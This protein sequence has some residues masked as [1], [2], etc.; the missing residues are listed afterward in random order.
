MSETSRAIGLKEL[1]RVL[2]LSVPTVS[3]ALGGYSDVSEKTRERV[4]QAAREHGYVASRAGR[5]LVSGRS[6]AIGMML[7]QPAGQITDAFVGEFLLGLA[8]SLAEL[9]R[10]LFLAASSQSRDEL[11]LLRHMVDG[12]QADGLVINRLTVD[13]ARAR[14]LIA[15]RIPFVAHGRLIEAPGPYS[16]LDTDGEKALDGLARRLVSLG[17]RRFALLMPD[18]AYTFA[19]FRSLG[20][21]RA[22]NELGL[23]LRPD[24]VAKVAPNDRDGAHDEARALLSLDPRPTAV[25]ALT[26]QLAFAVLDVARE[27]G[28]RVPED[29]SVVGFDNVPMAAYANPPL[30]T[31]DQ[32]IRESGRIAGDMVV[33]RIELGEAGIRTLLLEPKLELRASH[34]PAPVD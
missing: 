12:S 1:A 20:L 33:A 8:D 21:E 26:D 28:L 6:N 17:H 3:R 4:V 7:P 5:M 15:R 29:L 9:G 16:W 32:N 31:F 30:T 18:V 34:G 10:D 13:D 22:L 27:L 24:H 25:I 2:G 23:P 11:Q 14:V 19:H